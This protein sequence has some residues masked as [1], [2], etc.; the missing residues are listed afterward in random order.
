MTRTFALL[1]LVAAALLGACN[2]SD[3]VADP[4]PHDEADAPDS[5]VG[6]ASVE[7]GEGTGT[8]FGIAPGS[9]ARF[10]IFELF[11]G[12]PLI[13][14]GINTDVTGTITVEDEQAVLSPIVMDA[15]GFVTERGAA[16]SPLGDEIGWRDEAID[17]FILDVA[18]H[19]EIVFT[20]DAGTEITPD[21]TV[22]EGAL[23]VRDVTA[24]VSFD[25]VV[26]ETA[27]GW[28]V[29]GSADVLRSTYGLTI[30]GVAHIAEVADEIRLEIELL[31]EPIGT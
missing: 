9:E 20:P 14:E 10:Y 24:P 28:L 19:P 1:L 6:A 23:T 22:I 4:T 5:A 12:E 31:L 15:A 29:E 3:P 7:V 17:R 13:V 18:D 26:E 21:M 25:V 16:P 27:T 11:R 8:A 2:T 30:P